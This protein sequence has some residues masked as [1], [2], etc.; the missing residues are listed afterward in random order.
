ME[1]ILLT[2]C[3]HRSPHEASARMINDFHKFAS[4]QH[5]C[6]SWGMNF[7]GTWPSNSL[8][9]WT[10]CTSNPYRSIPTL[11]HLP[12]SFATFAHTHTPQC[13]RLQYH[14][15]CLLQRRH[16]PTPLRPPSLMPQR[17][18]LRIL[19]KQWVVRHLHPMKFNRHLFQIKKHLAHLPV[20][21]GLRN[22]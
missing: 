10:W 6:W 9:S 20:L 14:H 16:R 21:Q 4:K 1:G 18:Q 2:I 3:R 8:L 5:I 15:S 7:C 17:N 19:S 22:S 11:F 13:Q 12:H